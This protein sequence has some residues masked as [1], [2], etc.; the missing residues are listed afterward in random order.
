M[1]HH[2]ILGVAQLL[3]RFPMSGT[4]ALR[5][6]TKKQLIGPPELLGVG[7]KTDNTTS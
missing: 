7:Y 3:V 1:T 2:A 5:N 6:R 4:L